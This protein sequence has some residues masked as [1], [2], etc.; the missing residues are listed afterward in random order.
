MLPG[1]PSLGRG[2]ALLK[3]LQESRAGAAA[4]SEAS[5]SQAPDSPF[6]TVTAALAKIQVA[7]E[8]QPLD[9]Q[10][11]PEPVVQTTSAEATPEAQAQPAPTETAAEAEAQPDEDDLRQATI[12]KRGS[13]GSSIKLAAN[14]IEVRQAEG[15][16]FAEYS[17]RMDPPVDEIK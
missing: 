1:R 15:R 8:P 6:K 16:C 17:V 9:D 7:P 5:G 13:A 11:T 3:M 14:F 10:P 4:G 2:S 12:V